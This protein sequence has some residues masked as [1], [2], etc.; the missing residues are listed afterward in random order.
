[1]CVS[2]V[3][4]RSKPFKPQI[5][6]YIYVNC[7]RRQFWQLSYNLI[8]LSIA[9]INICWLPWT[10]RVRNFHSFAY[11]V[12]HWSEACTCS[13]QWVSIG[14]CH[15]R[16]WSKTLLIRWL[17]PSSSRLPELS[18]VFQRCKSSICLI[19]PM[20]NRYCHQID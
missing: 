13:L 17:P 11:S 18:L 3:C 20:Y 5:H 6:I 10:E 16:K 1:M 4:T 2:C 19:N 9:T 12:A 7:I 14:K 15:H 8:L